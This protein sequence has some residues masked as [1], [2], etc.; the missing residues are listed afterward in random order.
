MAEQIHDVFL[1]IVLGGQGLE[2]ISSHFAE[3][4]QRPVLIVAPA[5]GGPCQRNPESLSSATEPPTSVRLTEQDDMVSV[6]GESTACARTPV[7]AGSR[8]HGYVLVMDAPERSPLSS[9]ATEAA[10]TAAAFVLA[11]Q[12]EVVAH[13][14]K[15]QSDLMNQ[16]LR[17][18]ITEAQDV[19]RRSEPFGWDLERR[20]IVLVLEHDDAQQDVPDDVRAPTPLA[21][22]LLILV[23]RSAGCC[24][25]ARQ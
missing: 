1:Q 4:V 2:E 7:Y 5:G 15:Y 6:G 11:M 16:L 18:S 23:E 19:V 24:R 9:T 12:A 13:E 3:V 21:V 8:L 10:A 25:E 22:R 20:V 14:H 17:G